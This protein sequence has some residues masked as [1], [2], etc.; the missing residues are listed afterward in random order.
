MFLFEAGSVI[1]RKYRDDK[2]EIGNRQREQFLEGLSRGM[3]MIVVGIYREEKYR[4]VLCC[5]DKWNFKS[6]RKSMFRGARERWLISLQN[7]CRVCL[8]KS[9]LFSVYRSRSFYFGRY[10]VIPC[11]SRVASLSLFLFPLLSDFPAPVFIVFVP[12]RT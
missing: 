8:Q 1:S 12:L 7:I 5:P 10:F 6:L 11:F 3:S 9:L 4:V 2:T